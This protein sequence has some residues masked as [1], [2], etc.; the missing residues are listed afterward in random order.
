MPLAWQVKAALPQTPPSQAA[1]SLPAKP[2][3]AA[4]GP[5]PPAAASA[6]AA[7]AGADAAE[8]EDICLVLLEAAEQPGAS[9]GGLDGKLVGSFVAVLDTLPAQERSSK[10]RRLRVLLA[11][12]QFTGAAALMQMAVKLALAKAAQPSGGHNN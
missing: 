6:A 11:K 1:K 5:P 4:S 8:P 12:R 2:A 3:V 10:E 9:F 7:A